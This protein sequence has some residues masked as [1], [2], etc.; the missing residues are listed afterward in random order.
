MGHDADGLWELSAE[1]VIVLT[2]SSSLF[3]AGFPGSTTGNLL[4][5][6]RATLLSDEGDDMDIR[7]WAF[8][9]KDFR[10]IW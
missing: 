3:K 4:R 6:V 9:L 8:L 7:C 10:T 1:N 2:S 5:E